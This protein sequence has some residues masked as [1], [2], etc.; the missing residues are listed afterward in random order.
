[1][2]RRG[3]SRRR[4]YPSLLIS[5]PVVLF[6]CVVTLWNASSLNS[7]RPKRHRGTE[8]YI[9]RGEAREEAYTLNHDVK[10]LY[11]SLTGQKLYLKKAVRAR[12]ILEKAWSPFSGSLFCIIALSPL[13]ISLFASTNARSVNFVSLFNESALRIS[14][15]LALFFRSFLHSSS[16]LLGYF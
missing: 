8:I 9:K 6:R 10:L 7:S 12:S 13:Y 4:S 14:L 11:F 2:S 15:V 16:L 3:T 5:P 1:M